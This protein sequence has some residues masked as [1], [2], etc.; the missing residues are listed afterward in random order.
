MVILVYTYSRIDAGRQYNVVILL[1]DTLR[2][3]RLGAY[4]YDRPT[5]PNI[6]D[7]ARKSVV[8]ENCYA[9]APWTLPS[10]VSTDTARFPVEHDINNND[11]KIKVDT[12]TLAARQKSRGYTMASFYSNVFARPMSGLDQGYETCVEIVENL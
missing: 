4:G 12:E 6:D 11:A 8:C 9:S 1:I 5:T 3:D 7:L 2:A 10:I